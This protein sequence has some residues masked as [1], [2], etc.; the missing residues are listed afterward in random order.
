MYKWVVRI[1]Y[2]AF[3]VSSRPVAL[4][5]ERLAEPDGAYLLA[6]NH[7][8][9]FD[10]PCLMAQMPRGKHIDFVSVTEFF[11]NRLTAW[12]LRGVN[13]FP[14]DRHKVDGPTVRIILDRLAKGRL[15]AMFPEGGIRSEADSV[16][17]GGNIKPGLAK[18][19]QL[20]AVPVIPCVILGTKAYAKPTSW[21]PLKR[22]RYGVNYG[23]PMY[24]RTDL[25]QADG[26]TQFL[27]DIKRAYR[28]LHAELLDAMGQDVRRGSESLAAGGA[29][30]PTASAGR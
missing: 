10:V 19:A 4:H 30:G 2:H 3:W 14:L 7:L 11:Q 23:K 18:L 5:R 13:A 1:G 17:N 12:F 25:D 15:V 27:Q 26:R 28:D 29:A 8:S 24:V 9:P 21:L 16:L 22:V 20:A 6:P